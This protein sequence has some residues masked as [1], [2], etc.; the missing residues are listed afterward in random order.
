MTATP[1]SRGATSDTGTGRAR[2]GA[3]SSS[4]P[5]A[6][7]PRRWIS[8]VALAGMVAPAGFF[9]V[10]MVLGLV[11]PGGQPEAVGHSR[12]CEPGPITG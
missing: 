6:A 11:T 1:P 5:P 12:A 3:G 10:M 2:P 7:R 9:T 8:R 4:T